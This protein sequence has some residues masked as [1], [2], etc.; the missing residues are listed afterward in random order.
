MPTIVHGFDWPDRV[1]IGALGEPGARTFY[2]QARAG[3]RLTSVII[4]KEQSAALAE[5]IDEILDLLMAEEGNP[6]SVPS[7]TADELIDR[8]DLELPVE[9][10][11]RVGMFSLG[12]DPSTGQI[13]MEGYPY[14]DDSEPDYGSY[15]D[16]DTDDADD[17]LTGEP[18]GPPTRQYDVSHILSVRIP[19]GTA[20]AFAERA[21]DVVGAGRP[22]CPL[23]GMPMS[24]E[25]HVCALPG[26]P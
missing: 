12:W 14:A 17:E 21:R 13:V 18:G 26:E 3:S 24:P 9:P 11:F 7:A 23:C 25:G 4:E 2:L 22:A 8:D 20:R 15:V 5:K 1:V 19:V 6:F 10:E 16:D